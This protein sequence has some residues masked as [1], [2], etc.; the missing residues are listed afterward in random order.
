LDSNTIVGRT[1]F[2]IHPH[3][4]VKLVPVVG[5]TKDLKIEKI[6]NLQP[7][8]ILASKEENE[9]LQVLELMA[10]FDVWVTD[11]QNLDDNAMFLSELGKRLNK[12]ELAQQ[13]NARIETM[14]LNLK[15]AKPQEVTYLIWK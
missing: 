5:G 14:F 7:D 6:R 15:K 1:K 11:I 8:L 10:E 12:P 13:F 4:E 3:D 9:K 2:C